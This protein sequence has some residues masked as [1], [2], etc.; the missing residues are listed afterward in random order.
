MGLPTHSPAVLLPPLYAKNTMCSSRKKYLL[1]SGNALSELQNCIDMAPLRSDLGKLRPVGRIQS[2]APLCPARVMPM[3]NMVNQT[4]ICFLVGA[5][6][7]D[8]SKAFD[9]IPHALLV[10]KLHAYGFDEDALV[11]TY[12]YLKRRKQCV[13]INNEYSSFQEVISVVPQGSVLGPILFNFYIND[14]FFFKKQANLYNYTDDNTLA[15][16]SKIMPDLVKTLEKETGVALSWLKQNEMI[17]N[18]EKFHAI[19]LRKNRT[20]TSGEKINI[21]GETINSEET[22]KL[23]GVTLDY[24]HD[25]DPHIS[26][27]CKKA[28]T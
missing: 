16:F 21:D 22:V 5:I 12:S 18:P 24:R 25:F 27:I 4:S 7:M 8:L 6:L 13:R 26:N 1:L 9:C 15:Y 17:A 14:L 10:A 3:N 2:F 20:N 28:A 23:L 19:L 11:L